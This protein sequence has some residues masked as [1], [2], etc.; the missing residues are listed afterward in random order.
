MQNCLCFCWNT[1]PAIQ[2]DRGLS[3][4]I[5][6]QQLLG[7]TSFRAPRRDH[8]RPKRTNALAALCP[9]AERV[10]VEKED[11][12]GVEG[13]LSRLA[14]SVLRESEARVVVEGFI[15]SSRAISRVSW[16]LRRLDTC[17]CRRDTYSA[18]APLTATPRPGL[19]AQPHRHHRGTCRHG[20]ACGAS[21][22]L[23]FTAMSEC[24]SRGSADTYYALDRGCADTWRGS[25][26]QESS[27]E[28]LHLG[29]KLD[30]I[31]SKTSRWIFFSPTANPNHVFGWIRPGSNPKLRVL[32]GFGQ[33]WIRI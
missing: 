14:R 15:S 25:V 17:Q 27:L 3:A 8:G 9:T 2:P 26:T 28:R 1:I 16:L 12:G 23:V 7:C 5:Y 10:Q 32:V 13:A 29:S 6:I 24:A 21:I 11:V 19:G 18:L 4:A 30:Q 33:F 20:A 22:L 31:Q